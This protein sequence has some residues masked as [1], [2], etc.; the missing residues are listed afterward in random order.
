M[1]P[2]SG[3]PAPHII[4]PK[5]SHHTTIIALHGRGS[6][7]P[8]FA[9]E[10]FEDQTSQNRTLAEH[11]PH[12]KWIFPSSQSRYST[13]FQEEMDE[14]FDIYSLTNP[15]TQEGLQVQGLRDS[16][17][18]I[19]DI[20]SKEVGS[21]VNPSN[22]IL[23]GISQGCATA[24]HALLAG[25]ERLGGFI[26]IAGWMPF[27]KQIIDGSPLSELGLFDVNRTRDTERIPALL[28]HCADDDV[29]DKELGHQLRD[30][31]TASELNVDVTFK[32][33]PTGGH[34][35]PGPEG[36]DAI[37]GFLRDRGCD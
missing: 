26:G 25:Q 1:A 11:F 33:F 7:G 4:Q 8:E 13:V 16:I 28:C 19:L 18:H 22:I 34:W 5:Q 21:S 31:L 3:F 29:V 14:W 6:N 20:I 37:V 2:P 27:R 36:L 9:Q 30:A 35:I 24:I 15:S 10:L 17:T 32:E 23:M 12:T